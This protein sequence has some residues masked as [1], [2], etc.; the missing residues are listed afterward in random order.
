MTETID[1]P[2]WGRRFSIPVVYDC[3]AGETVTSEQINALKTFVKHDCW[4]ANA[5][6]QV[7]DYCKACVNND[8]ENHQK[9][10]I[11]SYVIPESIYVKREN[12]SPRVALM[13][14]YRYDIE[15]GLAI[16]FSADGSITIGYQD[17]IL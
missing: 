8:H 14:K 9:E 10:N 11:F 4:L 16:V 12:G 15:N 1:L 3:Y 7:E 2:I 5:K 13:C 17:I 6:K